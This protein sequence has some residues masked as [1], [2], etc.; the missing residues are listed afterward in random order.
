MEEKNNTSIQDNKLYGNYSMG[1]GGFSSNI[2]NVFN[3]IAD[4]EMIESYKTSMRRDI[5]RAGIPLNDFRNFKVLDVGTGRQSIAFHL[6]GAENVCHYDISPHNVERMNQFIVSNSLQ[7]KIATECVDLVQYVPPKSNFDLVYLHGIVQHFSHTGVGLRN[8]MQA[9]KQGGYLW[10]Y[11][12]R[13]GT[14]QKFVM[15]FLRDLLTSQAAI[16]H[17]EYFIN[18]IIL[19][20]DDCNPNYF[21]S[22]LMDLLFAAYVHLYTPKS[23]LSF[24]RNC[25][26]EV[27]FSSKLDLPGSEV[28]HKYAHESVVLVCKKVAEKDLAQCDVEILSPEKSINQLD[29]QIYSDDKD[30]E[31]LQTINEYNILKKTLCSNIPKSFIM[32]IILKI[33]NFSQTQHGVRDINIAE[34]D[35]HHRDFQLIFKNLRELI[36]NEYLIS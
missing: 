7:D 32:T 26:F 19:Y 25:G 21:A 20:S 18:S 11:F 22:G 23:Y 2:D 10:L 34:S 15:Y 27:T 36:K 8:C 5:Q 13:S 24:V 28:D 14:F 3:N 9:V 16:D 1:G 12:Y 17:R 4:Y 29:P 35:K 31:I 30:N 6:L 33:F